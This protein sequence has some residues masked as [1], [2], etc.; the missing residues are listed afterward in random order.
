[1]IEK[2]DPLEKSVQKISSRSYK[3]KH[4]K[5]TEKFPSQLNTSDLIDIIYYCNLSKCDLHHN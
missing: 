2:D 3:E 1:M 5:S 4:E